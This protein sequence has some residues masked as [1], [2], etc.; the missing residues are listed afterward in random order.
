MTA[1]YDF[2]TAC[3]LLL[4]WVGVAGFIA[5]IAVAVAPVVGRIVFE[6]RRSRSWREH[7]RQVNRSVWR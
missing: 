3:A 2:A 1:L 5:V 6:V 4:L 7:Q